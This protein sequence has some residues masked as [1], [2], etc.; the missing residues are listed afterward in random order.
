M[1]VDP[2][3]ADEVLRAAHAADPAV[4]RTRT[5]ETN[6]EVPAGWFSAR[7][8]DGLIVCTPTDSAVGLA[9][10]AGVDLSAAAIQA[11]ILARHDEARPG[12]ATLRAQAAQAV[13]DIDAYLLI[14]D[15]ATQ[16]QVRQCVKRLAQ[17]MRAVIIRLNNIE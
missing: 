4:T 14:A 16:A 11:R 13:A 1:A 10:A 6:E 5:V 7:R 3:A 2:V 15:T 12:R 17:A 8:P 9:A